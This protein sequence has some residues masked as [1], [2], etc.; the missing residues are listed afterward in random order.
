MRHL[1]YLARPTC[2][3]CTACHAPVALSVQTLES[4]DAQYLVAILLGCR[5]GPEVTEMG[6][7]GPLAFIHPDRPHDVERYEP[8]NIEEPEYPEEEEEE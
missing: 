5:C 1:V 3:V 2:Y 6:A 7:F 4:A 8:A